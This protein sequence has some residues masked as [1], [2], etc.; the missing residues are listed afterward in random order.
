MDKYEYKLRVEEI[1]SLIREFRY[2]EAAEV[3]DTID[4]RN[5]RNGKTL[6]MVSDLYKKCKRYEDSRDVLL[7]A[8]DRN[9][10]GRLIVYSLCELSLKLG[11]VVNAIEYLKA[12]GAIAPKD[13]GKYI[14]KYK[15][16]DSTG[17][18][19]GEKIE[20]LEELQQMECRERWMYE[21]AKLYKEDE[22][23]EK[24]IEECNQIIIYFGEGKY[25]IQA[26]E[27][28]A[29]IEPLSDE[30]EFLLK[31]LKSPKVD[32]VV[33]HM[34]ESSFNALDLQK[35]LADSMAEVMK[36]DTVVE[37]PPVATPV[38][39]VPAPAAIETEP[40]EDI[41][42]F[43]RKPEEEPEEK[44]EEN[45]VSSDTRVFDINNIPAEDDIEKPGVSK[46]IIPSFGRF[47]EMREVLPQ[48]SQTGRIVY[49]AYEDMVSL[50][51]DGQ[52]AINIP[53]QEV[54]E[55]QITGQISIEDILAE[56]ERLRSANE[57]T[58]RE[59]MRRKVIKQ[60]SDIFKDFDESSKTGLLEQLESEVTGEPLEK[61]SNEVSS[62][63]SFETIDGEETIIFV[64]EETESANTDS[65]VNT[66]NEAESAPVETEAEATEEKE[67]TIE[68]FEPSADIHEI[69]LPEEP[70]TEEETAPEEEPATE[71][72]PSMEELS[73]D[74]TPFMEE[75]KDDDIDN[76]ST[77]VLPSSR[78]I[79]D[80]LMAFA[81]AGEK[82]DMAIGAGV[83]EATE[84]ILPELPAEVIEEAVEE[85]IE[86][87]EETVEETADVSEEETT[88]EQFEEVPADG[89]EI[90][91]EEP[92]EEDN[93][94]EE[95][96]PEYTG[97]VREVIDE[98]NDEDSTEE[99]AE[100][101]DDC[102]IEDLEESEEE[103]EEEIEDEPET[104]ED[105]DEETDFEEEEDSLPEIRDSGFTEEQEERFESFIQTEEAREQL[106]EVLA[107]MSMESCTGNVIIGS[108]DIDSAVELAKCLIME[109]SEVESLT[110]KVAKIKAS[111]L[112]AKD[113][114]ETLAKIEDG[115]L[116][117]QDANEL[118]KNTLE[119]L[120]NILNEEDKR[121]FIVLLMNKR[122]K[123]K[124]IMDNTDLMD[125]FNVS[126]DIEA[127]N[128]KELANYAK[129]YAYS[130]EFSIDEMGLL[131]LHT[132]IEGRQTN[133][134]SVTVSEVKAIVDEAIDNASRKNVNHFIDLLFGKRYDENDMV[135]LKEKD[136]AE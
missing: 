5:V 99:P 66:G 115:A 108:E 13:P 43:E 128:D 92:V 71:E 35:E 46:T 47:D 65:E 31:Q 55:K 88:E 45:V 81:E 61:I 130:R 69:L 25:V 29:E 106:L 39:E 84:A 132:R 97:A 131:A 134:H 26:L 96:E 74:R 129:A 107:E 85:I 40:E 58:W 21:L 101:S 117:I 68:T 127:L 103:P 15:L 113:P 23:V 2:I 110:G 27:L 112:N 90:T 121:I 64:E 49:P 60:T 80:Y 4:W 91:E 20:V 52:I 77:K 24:C 136:F 63:Y 93:Q 19:L 124:F 38:V 17:A 122:N 32:I 14:L 41:K 105:Q 18:S 8:Y 57:E 50:Q 7:L 56:W 133:D 72:H 98:L 67:E 30:E 11:D 86:V 3:A 118:S 48:N 22:N 9:P 119:A 83:L 116:I 78:E 34:D 6:C 59:N 111:T 33:K 51:G 70:A 89:E 12:F 54:V 37:I 42:V 102:E 109:L 1:N 120:K 94:E 73:F 16:Y 87:P 75:S 62:E 95:T 28:K 125:C 100:V 126:Y 135:V 44:P 53:E 123:H 104:E 10:S 79:D 76:L 36:E 114:V 82:N